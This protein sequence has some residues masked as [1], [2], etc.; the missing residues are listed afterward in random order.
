M[1]YDHSFHL[2]LKSIL[3]IVYFAKIIRSTADFG[4][5]GYA[6]LSLVTMVTTKARD[7]QP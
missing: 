2:H 6:P 4:Y 1:T 5:H 3:K 7:V